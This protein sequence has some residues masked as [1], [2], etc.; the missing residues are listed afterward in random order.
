MP[1]LFPRLFIILLCLTC[2]SFLQ[3]STLGCLT[4]LHSRDAPGSGLLSQPDVAQD[5][6]SSAA[7]FRCLY[8]LGLNC[9]NYDFQLPPHDI[10]YQTMEGHRMQHPS[11]QVPLLQGCLI[12]EGGCLEA[13]HHQ[14]ALVQ[15]QRA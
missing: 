12:S 6:F 13:K 4:S 8:L 9:T 5:E 3:R 7:F 14:C 15:A 11:W 1:I 2:P 10:C